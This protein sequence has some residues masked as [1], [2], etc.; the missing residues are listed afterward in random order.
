MRINPKDKMIDKNKME[1]WVLRKS[2]ESY[3]PPSVAWRQK[4]Q[5]SDGVG[6]DWIDGLKDFI[7]TQITDEEFEHTI[8]EMKATVSLVSLDIPKTKEDLYYRRIFDEKFPNREHI[9][10]RWIPRTDWDGVSYDPSGRAQTVH[11]NHT[12]EL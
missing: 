4:E 5:F 8:E 6:Y 9:V 12:N 7:E 2:F 10:P 1:K 11:T 3:L